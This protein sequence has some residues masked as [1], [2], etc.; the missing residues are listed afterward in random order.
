MTDWLLDSINHGKSRSSAPMTVRSADDWYRLREIVP[1]YALWPKA[2]HPEQVRQALALFSCGSGDRVRS[3]RPARSEEGLSAPRKT[4]RTAGESKRSQPQ[5]ERRLVD[6]SSLAQRLGV[7]TRTI[8]RRIPPTHRIS[9]GGKPLYDHEQVLESLRTSEQ[10]QEISGTIESGRVRGKKRSLT[11]RSH[12]ERVDNSAS[13]EVTQVEQE[14]LR[15]PRKR[16]P[17]P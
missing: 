1:A 11:Y 16:R 15:A 2:A 10:R 14:L 17:A 13:D 12:R 7:S 6:Q 5:S 9:A 8:R 4:S 3:R